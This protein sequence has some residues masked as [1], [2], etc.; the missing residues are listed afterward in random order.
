MGLRRL[1]PTKFVKLSTILRR[2][3]GYNAGRKG[4]PKI[5]KIVEAADN[6]SFGGRCG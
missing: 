2:E 6:C 1:K 3:R 5:L 4:F